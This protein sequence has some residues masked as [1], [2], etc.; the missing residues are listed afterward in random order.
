[1]THTNIEPIRAVLYIRLY[2]GD[3][4]QKDVAVLD[5]RAQLEDYC[6]RHGWRVVGEYVDTDGAVPGNRPVFDQM[7]NDLTSGAPRCDRVVI[8][9]HSRF[10]RDEIEAKLSMHAL[11][12]GG[13]EVTSI[14]QEVSRDEM[15]DL[16]R[17]LR[18][19]FKENASAMTS[20]CLRRAYRNNAQQGFWYGGPAPYGFRTYVASEPGEAVKKKLKLVPVEADVVRKMFDLLEHGDG[21]SG[22]MGVKSITAWLNG[23]GY[24][25]RRGKN[26]TIGMVQRLLTNSAVKGDYIFG[27]NAGIETAIHISVPEIIPAHRFDMAQKILR[28]RNPR[29]NQ[30]ETSHVRVKI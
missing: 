21:P 1:M 22:P 6:A 13:I 3:R 11:R 16:L 14:T 29:W 18:M 20:E 30:P 24:R 19:H 2:S 17:R 10:A 27:K 28:A 12:E 23:N 7:I 9:S 4:A 5:Q 15:G 25:T 26:W 8:H